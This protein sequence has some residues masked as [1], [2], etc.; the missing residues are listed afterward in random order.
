VK[1]APP[2]ET[3]LRRALL[4]WRVPGVTAEQV[5]A[6]FGISTYALRRARKSLDA[7]I[8]WTDDDLVQMALT[9][10]TRPITED[11]MLNFIDWVNHDRWP[12][13][14]LAT[15][16]VRLEEAGKIHRVGDGWSL[17]AEWP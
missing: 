7:S 16:L 3:L 12:K 8:R 4:Y 17:A 1:R 2:D 9:R 11:E 14:Q 6:R 5:C 13:D 10:A 15:I